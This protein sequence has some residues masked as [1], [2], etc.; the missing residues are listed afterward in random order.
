GPDAHGV[1]LHGRRI[2]AA[3]GAGTELV[4]ADLL[5]EVDPALLQDRRIVVQVT[6]RVLA[7]RRDDALAAWRRA[8]AGAVRVTVVLHDLPQASDGHHRGPRSAIYA[9]LCA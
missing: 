7:P 8:T 9:A 2:Q 1:V 5:S 3:T 4:R 6:D